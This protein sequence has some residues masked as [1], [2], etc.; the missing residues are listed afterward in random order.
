MSFEDDLRILE[1]Q[2]DLLQFSSF[3]ANDVWRLVSGIRA[4]A[5]GRSKPVAVNIWMSGQTLFYA[6]TMA[7]N[8]R[9]VTPGNEDWLRRK[10][11]TVIRFGRSS[12]RV[13]LELE[14]DGTTLDIRQGL[15]LAD[16]AAHGGGFP[17]L[18]RGT[19]CVGAI[20]VS[21]LTQREDHALVVE[22]IAADLGVHAR[23]LED[24]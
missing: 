8:G 16:F 9:G 10:R 13:G 5:D 14:R 1:T 15:P 4:L 24:R 3:S 21:G 2:E 18:L 12:L 11:N 22:A 17:L 23:Q 20:V 6:A 7:A 19:G